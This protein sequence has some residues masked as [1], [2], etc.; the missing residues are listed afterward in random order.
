[1]PTRRELGLCTGKTRS[2]KVE[3][4]KGRRYLEVVL[5]AGAVEVGFAVEVGVPRRRHSASAT[6]HDVEDLNGWKAG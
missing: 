5:D 2:T 6:Q 1:M 4:Q 3:R